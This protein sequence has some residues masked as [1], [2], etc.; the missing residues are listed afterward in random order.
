MKKLISTMM[1][2]LIGMTALAQDKGQK[3]VVW[4]NPSAFMGEYNSEFKIT[5][6][7]LTETETVLHIFANY[8][9]GYWIRLAKE[10]FVKTADGTK[11]GNPKFLDK[12]QNKLSKLQKAFAKT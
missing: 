9:P 10:S 1:L 2:V 3:Q 4:E 12:G 7:E 6:V 5:K 8:S 11:Y